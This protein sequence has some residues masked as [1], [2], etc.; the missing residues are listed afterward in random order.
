VAIVQYRQYIEKDFPVLT[1][2]LQFPLINPAILSFLR[3]LMSGAN[4]SDFNKS[5]EFPELASPLI[6]MNPTTLCKGLEPL[7]SL[8]GQVVDGEEEGVDF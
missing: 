5:P 4:C 3:G 8:G 6:N 1:G 7:H 2:S